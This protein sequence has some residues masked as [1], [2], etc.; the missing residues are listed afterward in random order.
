MHAPKLDV[1]VL[2]SGHFNRDTIPPVPRA[3]AQR[4]VSFLE[5]RS[6]HR[7]IRCQIVIRVDFVTATNDVQAR[8]EHLG[9]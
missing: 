6:D 4:G 8:I 1:D 5:S 9:V 2:D 3:G 7:E